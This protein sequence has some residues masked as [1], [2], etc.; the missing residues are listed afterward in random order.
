MGLSIPGTLIHLDAD[1]GV[2]DRF[3]PVDVGIVADAELGLE[4]LLDAL[5]SATRRAR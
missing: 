3:H 2:I 4:A 1:P 5:A